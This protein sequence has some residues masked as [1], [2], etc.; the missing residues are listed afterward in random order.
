MRKYDDAIQLLTGRRFAV[1]EGGNLN[2][3]DDWTNAHLLRGRQHLMAGRYKQALVDFEAAGKVPDNLPTERFGGFAG[4]GAEL[5][6]WIGNA[7]EAIGDKTKAVDSWSKA[8]AS[9]APRSRRGPAPRADAQ[10]Y[11]RALSLQKLG[12]GSEVNAMFQDLVKAGSESMPQRSDFFASFDN[13]QQSRSR[14][15]NAHYV[16]ALGHLG[17][18]DKTKA[19]ESLDKVLSL[20]PSHVWARETLAGLN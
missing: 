2:V 4:R 12:K 5:A 20:S 6:Y 17:L 3:A 14:Q 7:W 16:A 9:S 19:K 10:T 13:E 18:G 15:A 8:L 1:W 11:Y